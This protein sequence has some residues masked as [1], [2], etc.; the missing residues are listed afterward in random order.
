MPMPP[1]ILKLKRKRNEEPVETLFIHKEFRNSKRSFTNIDFR[2]KRL[3][4]LDN[5]A[6]QTKA[7]NA[8]IYRG[9]SFS[10][11]PQVPTVRSTLQAE[12]SHGAL[13][14]HLVEK[15]ETTENSTLFQSVSAC[16]GVASRLDMSRL[17][18]RKFHLTQDSVSRSHQILTTKGGVQKRKKNQRDDVAVFSER[19]MNVFHAMVVDRTPENRGDPRLKTPSDSIVAPQKSTS[20]SVKRPNASA[21]EQIWRKQTWGRPM[22]GSRTTNAPHNFADGDTAATERDYE[23]LKLASELQQFAKE[24]TGEDTELQPNLRSRKPHAKAQLKPPRERNAGTGPHISC[25]SELAVAFD[26]SGDQDDSDE[27]ITETYVRS[28]N[29]TSPGVPY[30]PGEDAR[31]ASSSFGLLVITEEDEPAW[32]IYGGDESSDSEEE[33]DGTDSNAEDYYAN[34]YPE[35][36]VNSDD[37]HGRGA[38]DYR[39]AG[40][41]D[42]EYD[43]DAATFSDQ[44]D[45][46]T[47]HRET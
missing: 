19:T 36:E 47:W 39:H 14:H 34:D 45:S 10:C 21:A 18:S 15:P 22:Q 17:V 41:D 1:E 26:Q 30:A 23:I 35:D 20:Y 27:W 32:E 28:V 7:E 31:K 46:K 43:E 44:D 11:V 33:S 5:R 8:V 16:V 12:E 29:S 42:E 40:S 4:T 2:F 24:Q 25:A 3:S 38:Y 9:S 13:E 37:E 6:A